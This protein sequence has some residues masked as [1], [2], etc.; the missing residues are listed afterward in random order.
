MMP[1][2]DLLVSE[3]FARV[4]RL[5]K[6]K[7]VPF[8]WIGP[9][10]K[11][12]SQEAYSDYLG[13]SLVYFNPTY[14]SPRPGARTEAMLAGC[15]I[16]TTPYQDADTFIEDGVNG[17]LTSK[18]RIKDPRI[19]DSP[20]YTANLLEKLVMKEPELAIRIGKEGRRTAMQLFSHDKFAEQWKNYLKGIGIWK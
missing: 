14:Q 2:S 12:G 4:R 7:G 5:L 20:E 17:F 10:K 18:A 11:F 1:S 16:V 6:D 13:R 3:I 15:C 19:M 9:D 8:V